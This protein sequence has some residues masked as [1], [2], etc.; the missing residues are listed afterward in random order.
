MS[1]VVSLKTLSTSMCFSSWN[2][3]W[4]I[5]LLVIWLFIKGFGMEKDAG[6]ERERERESRFKMSGDLIRIV[7]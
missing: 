2:R 1:S 7:G 5:S 4:S 6:R 3:L